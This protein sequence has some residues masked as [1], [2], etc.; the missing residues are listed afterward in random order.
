MI[1]INI[2]RQGG[3]LAK[4]ISHPRLGPALAA[5]TKN[6]VGHMNIRL[7]V[8]DTKENLQ[9]LTNTYQ[10]LPF[11]AISSFEVKKSSHQKENSNDQEDIYSRGDVINGVAIVNSFWPNIQETFKH[12]KK[13]TKGFRS[14]TIPLFHNH[15]DDLEAESEHEVAILHH[16]DLRNNDNT[17]SNTDSMKGLF[18][19]KIQLENLQ[20]THFGLVEKLEELQTEK[21]NSLENQEQFKKI[22]SDLSHQL[23]ELNTKNEATNLELIEKT[24]EDINVIDNM[25]AQEEKSSAEINDLIDKLD[26][27][28]TSVIEQ[29]A[30]LKFEMSNIYQTYGKNPDFQITLSTDI[31]AFDEQ[32]ILV[33]MQRQRQADKYDFVANNCAHS[34]KK[35]LLKGLLPE[36]KALLQEQLGVKNE[37]FQVTKLETPE[38]VMQWIFTLQNYLHQ[39]QRLS[40][41]LQ[42]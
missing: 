12:H 9:V 5:L 14:G 1:I 41:G 33:E 36:V 18:K 8:Y 38:L 4:K 3:K 6:N 28:L 26:S 42:P 15:Q 31:P 19:K 10:E 30:Q 2:W 24:T 21:N 40:S 11:E 17:N 35:C 39:V 27:E 32:A 20:Q 13:I 22:K 25:I 37:F 16:V 29:S 23:N 7:E 34:V